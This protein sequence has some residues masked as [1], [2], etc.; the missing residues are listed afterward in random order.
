MIPFP[1]HHIE[2][3]CKTLIELKFS[4]IRET[5]QKTITF[6][7]L[8]LQ[9]WDKLS[10]STMNLIKSQ[11]RTVKLVCRISILRLRAIQPI[12][13]DFWTHKKY[14]FESKICRQIHKI[15]NFVG[16]EQYKGN[17]ETNRRIT[18]LWSKSQRDSNRIVDLPGLTLKDNL[19]KIRMKLWNQTNC[20]S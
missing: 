10:P 16:S 1:Q 20:E 6:L 9:S 13:T 2:K 18:C 5:K 4:N 17:W 7:Y 8:D 19:N 3:C 14:S 15:P 11:N 12:I